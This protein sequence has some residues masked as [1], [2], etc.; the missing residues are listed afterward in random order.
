MLARENGMLAVRSSFGI[1]RETAESFQEPLD[2]RLMP[3][4]QGLLSVTPE[5]FLGVPLVVGGEVTGILAV[6]LP[7]GTTG[8]PD[9]EWLLSAL[10]D[11]AAVALEKTRLDQVAEFRERLIGIVSHDLRN[12]LN[13]ILLGATLLEEEELGERAQHILRRVRNS[14]ELA[15][16]LIRDLLDYTQAHLGGEIPVNKA[17]ADLTAIVREA[18]DDVNATN[19]GARVI[20]EAQGETRGQWDVDRMGQV[21]GNLLS[22]ALQYSPANSPVRVDLRREGDSV[23]ITVHNDGAAIPADQLLRIFEPMRRGAVA[24]LSAALRSVGLGLYIVRHIIKSH[25]GS[26][27]V[28]STNEAGTTFIATLPLS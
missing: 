27:A 28:T 10:A 11:Q 23:I 12:P 14:T 5:R 1:E 9:Q 25:G 26:V 17:A 16:R 2:E 18:V 20:L 22:N 3:R 6:A 19:P 15:G 4:L 13:A 21:L 8:T 24:T 7:P